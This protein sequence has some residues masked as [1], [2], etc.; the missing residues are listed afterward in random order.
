MSASIQAGSFFAHSRW[1]RRF[2]IERPTPP[3]FEVARTRWFSFALWTVSKNGRRAELRKDRKLGGS[4]GLEDAESVQTIE[5]KFA[6]VLIAYINR[7]RR[8]L[9]SDI[10]SA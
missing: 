1:I 8:A 5:A 3:S 10:Y 2:L 9:C 4:A 6:S 7:P